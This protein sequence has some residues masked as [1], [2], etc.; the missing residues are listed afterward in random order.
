MYAVIYLINSEFR[1]N[2]SGNVTFSSNVGSLMALNSRVTFNGFALFVNNRPDP[3]QTTTP[4][5]FYEGGA[6]TLIQS[7]TFFNGQC[8]LK[9]NHVKLGG[10]IHSTESKLYVNGNV[11]IAHNTATGNGGGVYLSNSELNCQQK[12][13]FVL[14]NNTAMSKGG[15]LHAISSSIKAYTSLEYYTEN[16][17]NYIDSKINLTK[18]A[19]MLGG[20]LSLE[21]NANFIS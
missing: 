1:G 8:T 11:T 13:T 3:S 18:N 6:I 14:Y 9:H 16:I 2:H 5:N 20:G 10:A 7:D 21:A 12:S 4:D 15:G 19:A 17:F